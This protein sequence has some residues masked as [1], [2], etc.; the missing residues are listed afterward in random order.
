MES[1]ETIEL[2]DWLYSVLDGVHAERANNRS[3]VPGDY[4]G[5]TEEG[6]SRKLGVKCGTVEGKGFPT[7][8]TLPFQA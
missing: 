8:G 1:R 4:L 6:H 7:G 5:A 2:M 3:R